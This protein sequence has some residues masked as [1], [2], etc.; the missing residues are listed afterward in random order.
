MFALVFA[1][2]LVL[3]CLGAWSG[4]SLWPA[5]LLNKK[6]ESDPEGKDLG[7]I[8][9]FSLTWLP[10]AVH[11]GVYGAAAS[12][13]FDDFLHI[14][15]A[16]I[17]GGL[18]SYAGMQTATRPALGWGRPHDG[19]HVPRKLTPV[20]NFIA[21]RLLGF[22]VGDINYCRTWMA[23]KGFIISLPVGGFG[24]ITWPLG[25]DIGDRLG[26]NLY[27]E[28]LASAFTS[29]WVIVFYTMTK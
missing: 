28:F 1:F 14:M 4:G 17:V 24:F 15:I 26:K 21:V 13:A 9:P 18:I 16:F 11:S 2:F 22:S 20:V 12:F 27:R 19:T 10:E 5:H 3:G 8:M 23:V 7:G 6:G 29:V 25:Y